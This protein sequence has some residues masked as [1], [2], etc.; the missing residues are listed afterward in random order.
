MASSPT[1]SVAC[2][3]SIL[4]VAAHGSPPDSAAGA[5]AR[6]LV[7]AAWKTPPTRVDLVVSTERLLPTRGPEE[8]R[9]MVERS[10]AALGN[11]QENLTRREDIDLNVRRILA[12]QGEPRYFVKRIRVDGE[13]SRLDVARLPSLAA[14]GLA[15]RFRQ[16]YVHRGSE[17]TPEGYKSFEYDHD[18]GVVQ[19]NRDTARFVPNPAEWAGLPTNAALLVK[20]AFGKP[21]GA[22]LVP[23]DA[24]LEGFL[25][26]GDG[27][28]QISAREEEGASDARDHVTLLAGGG[29]AQIDLVCDHNDY[30][31]VYR[32][33]TY[34]EGRLTSLRQADGFDASEFPSVCSL[35]RY[36][37]QGRIQEAERVTVL[38]TIVGAPIPPEVFGFHPPDGYAILDTRGLVVQAI[39]ERAPNLA[40][41]GDTVEHA[42]RDG[43]GAMSGRRRGWEI[44]IEVP[45]TTRATSQPAARGQRP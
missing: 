15:V 10:F 37:A 2:I 32:A 11:M 45:T 33:E 29:A 14:F 38:Q 4:G 36:D 24:K 31:R 18:A 23:D 7:E 44:K 28:L 9:Q 20:I 35:E 25:T 13:R 26:T 30:S 17:A 34:N 1:A 41:V 19:I 43:S 6:R 3:V 42:L 39:R 8:V 27:M 12:E 16:T 40:R 5:A 22:S 21:S